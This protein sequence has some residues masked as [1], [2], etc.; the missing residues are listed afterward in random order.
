MARHVA[1][2]AISALLT[3]QSAA[4]AAD[5]AT[6]A[7]GE[8]EVTVR[9]ALPNVEDTRVSKTVRNCITANGSGSRGL[10]VLG[11]NNP[12]SACPVRNVRGQ[13]KELRFDIVCPGSNA[14]IGMARFTLAPTG[15]EGSIDI[16]MGGKNMTM[17]ERQVGRRIGDCTP[18]NHPTPTPGI[19]NE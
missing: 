14:A 2:V 8:Y 3:I 6:L 11:D 13:Q 9:L 17:S 19:A 10:G 1:A 12:L 7:A 5:Q 4:L 18:A 15:F 16:K